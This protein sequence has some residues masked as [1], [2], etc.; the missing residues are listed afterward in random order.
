MIVV[1][2]SKLAQFNSKLNSCRSSYIR[3]SHQVV[4]ADCHSA[5]LLSH[6]VCLSV[7]LSVT[8]SH[9]SDCCITEGPVF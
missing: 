7:R 5:C 2:L 4:S 3:Q 6:S 1:D 9:V 8:L